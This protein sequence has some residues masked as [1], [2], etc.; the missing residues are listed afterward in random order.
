ME[1]TIR[2]S[3]KIVT[4][5]TISRQVTFPS[6]YAAVDVMTFNTIS[7]VG[8]ITY[9]D[10]KSHDIETSSINMCNTALELW[11]NAAP[12]HADV[13]E[14]IKVKRTSAN[15]AGVYVGED[16]FHTDHETRAQYSIMYA[17]ISV[18]LL[19]NSHVFDS[20]WKTMDGEFREMT[21][22]LLKTIIESGMSNESQNY[23][24]AEVHKVAM[25]GSSDPETYDYSTNWT[26]VHV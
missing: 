26:A 2:V 9:I 21:V 1:I 11:N 16:W 5:G 25:L 7:N 17:A 20:S 15:T 19:S 24:N 23:A 8:L 14:L 10:Q 13:W 4:V 6:E 22:L 18:N 12:T 3:D